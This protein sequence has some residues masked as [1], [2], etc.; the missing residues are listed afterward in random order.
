MY[1]WRFAKPDNS[2]S[3]LFDLSYLVD[4]FAQRP[5]ERM[6][7][8]YFSPFREATGE[9]S[10]QRVRVEP[11]QSVTVLWTAA[12]VLP[13]LRAWL[14][15]CADYQIRTERAEQFAEAA[16]KSTEGAA[17]FTNAA[18]LAEEEAKK[19]NRVLSVEYHRQ[20]VNLT[21]QAERM[22]QSAVALASASA[23]LSALT[24][25]TNYVAI[26]AA[27][28]V[29]AASAVVA[30]TATRAST[31]PASWFFQPGTGDALRKAFSPSE[32]LLRKNDVIL[33]VSFEGG[34]ELADALF[35]LRVA[36]RVGA[37]RGPS[38][39]TVS[40]AIRDVAQL[41]PQNDNPRLLVEKLDA[42][43]M[44]LAPDGYTDP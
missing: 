31:I 25:L 10:L 36:G 1:Y 33:C 11:D 32:R 21:E 18:A 43:F 30:R 2:T 22:E 4:G 39:Q 6:T 23:S 9:I 19:T 3:Y 15:D 7:M 42:A 17:A 20:A 24:P 5:L 38:E 14:L 8:A 26:R 27:T 37:H 40:N 28:T 41:D 12:R 34:N 35:W 29:L 16:A 44:A 13:A